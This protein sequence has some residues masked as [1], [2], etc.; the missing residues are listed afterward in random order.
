MFSLNLKAK[1]ASI[2]SN[3]LG[4]EEECIKQKNEETGILEFYENI[5]RGIFINGKKSR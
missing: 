4:I 3:L 2:N 1:Y 5:Y